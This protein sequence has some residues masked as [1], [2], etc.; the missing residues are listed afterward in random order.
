MQS[1][2]PSERRKSSFF[3]HSEEEEDE[4]SSGAVATHAMVVRYQKIN[5]NDSMK[6]LMSMGKS[7]RLAFNDREEQL[8][9]QH[10]EQCTLLAVLHDSALSLKIYDVGTVIALRTCPSLIQEGMRW[11]SKRQS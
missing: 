8:Q 7:W 1:H 6:S 5:N 2:L 4:S 11:P 3:C 10:K 9:S